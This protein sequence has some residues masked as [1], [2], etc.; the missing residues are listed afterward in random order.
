MFTNGP[1]FDP[2]LN[3]LQRL[4]NANQF[5]VPVS[6]PPLVP[7]AGMS[8]L[9]GAGSGHLTQRNEELF[10]NIARLLRGGGVGEGLA[11]VSPLQTGATA[12][13]AAAS[14]PVP[15][16]FNP[17][18]LFRALSSPGGIGPGRV[19]PALPIAPPPPFAD[20]LTHLPGLDGCRR[21][22]FGFPSACS[23]G[24]L[25]DVAPECEDGT[26]SPNAC[27]LN[28]GPDSESSCGPDGPTGAGAE[29]GGQFAERSE[30]AG[31][32]GPNALE[33]Y[34]CDRCSKAFMWKSN[35]IRHQV[36]HEQNRRF[37]CESCDKV[38]T[39]ASNLQRHIR[40][41]HVGARSHACPQ[42]GK[43]YSNSTVHCAGSL[44]PH[45]ISERSI[46]RSFL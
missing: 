19:V 35:L 25:L 12:T 31:A 28:G 4:A 13:S 23:D 44:V 1:A 36:T 6:P 41:Q 21:G 9:C 14:A 43:V 30:A 34:R 33:Q 16:S 27:E 39:D 40:S 26:Q 2:L 10:G 29:S 20:A 17:L 7:G 45:I 22:Q 15:A 11:F 46:I 37:L 38:F 24:E 18:L 5:R 3:T 8:Q 32:G 42:C